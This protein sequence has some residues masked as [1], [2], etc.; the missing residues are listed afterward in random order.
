MEV[1]ET[2]NVLKDSQ[3]RVKTMTIVHEKL[4]QSPNLKDI[5]FKE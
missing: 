3:N 4:Y 1:E 5:N 2:I